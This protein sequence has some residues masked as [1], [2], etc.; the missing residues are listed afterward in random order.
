MTE[1]NGPTTLSETVLTK[2]NPIRALLN[3]ADESIQKATQGDAAGAERLQDID[4]MLSGLFVEYVQSGSRADFDNF[5]DMLLAFLDSRKGDRLKE[6]AGGNR[7]YYRWDHFHDLCTVVLENYDASRVDRFVASRKHAP[8]LMQTLFD[9]PDG[10]RHK[11]LADRLGISAQHLSKL[12]KEIKEY[13]LINVDKGSATAFVKLSLL[14][15]VH[16][17]KE[18]SSDATSGKAPAAVRPQLTDNEETQQAKRLAA[19]GEPM[20]LLVSNG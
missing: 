9:N 19:L 6:I 10:V 11:D 15:R 20:R 13:R 5:I 14:G 16:M 8:E 3:L 12:L 7:Y 1:P 18:E 4:G 17:S 2:E